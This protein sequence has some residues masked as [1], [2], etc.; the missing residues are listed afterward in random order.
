M[1]AICG[2]LLA[3]VFWITMRP[4]L[5][6]PAFLSTNYRGH[7]VPTAG[8]LVLVLVVVSAEAIR[9][10]VAAAGV[11]DRSISG[12]RLYVLL[13][14][15]GFGLLGLL[16][17]LG[18]SGGTQGL[19][20]HARAAARGETTTGALKLAGGVALSFCLAGAAVPVSEGAAGR[21]VDLFVAAIVVAAAAN[22]AN[23]FDRGPGRTAKLST[24]AFVVLIGAAVLHDEERSLVA[25]VL[26]AG[27]LLGIA[28]D[29]L[30][31]RV[32]LG[33]TGANV[34]GAMAGLGLVMTTSTRTQAIWA[35]LLVSANLA[36]ELISFSRLFESV[37]VLRAFDQMGTLRERRGHRGRRQGP[38]VTAAPPGRPGSPPRPRPPGRRPAGPRGERRPPESRR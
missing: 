1:A 22:L 12:E 23:L 26:V 19:R 5:S 10:I 18:E 21:L 30:H 38:A 29:D 15:L 14:T 17:D 3:R 32:M 16:D 7:T 31:E 37:G 2:F 20:G 33:D 25:V 36:S 27:G 35:V 24:I 9:T 6:T 28:Y 4:V 11:G 13:G 34:V 8:G